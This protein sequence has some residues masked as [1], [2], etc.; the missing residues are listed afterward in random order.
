MPWWGWILVGAVLLVAEIGLA[1][2]FYLVFFGVGA[3]TLAVLGLAGVVLPAWAQWL[4]FAAVAV[5][6]LALFRSR[7]RRT[8][9][10]GRRPYDELRGEIATASERLA[11]GAVGHAELRG[12]QWQ[13][14][15]G[16]P[17]ELAPG[18]RCRVEAVDGLM[19]TV[20]RTT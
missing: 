7:L 19:L 2:D 16:G 11:A 9:W 5:G 15:N 14:R 6:S 4:L 20:R 13:V 18:D 12:A 3:F 8:L 10:A 17:E 1:T